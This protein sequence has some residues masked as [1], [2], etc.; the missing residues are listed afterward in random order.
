MGAGLVLT[1]NTRIL[2][3]SG[4]P[5]LAFVQSAVLLHTRKHMHIFGANIRVLYVYILEKKNQINESQCM[6]WQTSNEYSKPL[7]TGSIMMHMLRVLKNAMKIII[8]APSI[9]IIK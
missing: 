9:N 5:P 8:N 7:G 2:V 1:E 6:A 4:R 3:A